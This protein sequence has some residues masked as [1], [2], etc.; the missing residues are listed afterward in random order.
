MKSPPPSL[1]QNHSR[2]FIIPIGGAEDKRGEMRIHRR[3]IALSGESES[4]IVV[5][6]SA[7]D[8]PSIGPDYKEMFLDLGAAQVDVLPIFSREA[9]DDPNFEQALD[10]TSGIFITGGEPMRLSNI[11]SGTSI[12]RKILQL[13][14][15][16]IPVAGTS[17]G[18]TFMAK[19]MI[20]SGENNCGPHS[21]NSTLLPGLGLDIVPVIDQHFSERNRLGRL[22]SA[23]A[24]AQS[25]LG[26]GLDENTAAFTGPDNAFEVIGSGSVTVVDATSLS[27]S[28]LTRISESDSL[29]PQGIKIVILKEG[30]RYAP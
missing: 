7:S 28:A 26:I 22:L 29:N 30:D 5:I 11:L 8:K 20:E 23:M 13:N 16:G 4:R 10:R 25:V 17:A 15:C 19:A 18:A 9:C 3:F 27:C 14:R 24:Q 2:G 1:S 6:P 12:A 21:S